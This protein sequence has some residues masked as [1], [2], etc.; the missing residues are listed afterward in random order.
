MK[1]TYDECGFCDEQGLSFSGRKCAYCGG[2]DDAQTRT[3]GGEGEDPSN[4]AAGR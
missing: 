3:E 4:V 2:R 1:P